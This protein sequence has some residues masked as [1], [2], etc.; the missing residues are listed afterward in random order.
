MHFARGFL[1]F[2]FSYI[3]PLLPQTNAIKCVENFTFANDKEAATA[4]SQWEIKKKSYM[5][6]EFRKF[7]KKKYIF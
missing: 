3:S 1:V 2:R 7:E 6:K 4:N 5:K